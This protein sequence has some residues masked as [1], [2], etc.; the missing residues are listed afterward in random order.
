MDRGAWLLSMAEKPTVHRVSKRVGQDLATEQQQMN[1]KEG[2]Q[3]G[4]RSPCL[5]GT[6]VQFR[7]MKTFM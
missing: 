6:R 1:F 2:S 4:M 5:M 3:A 7:K